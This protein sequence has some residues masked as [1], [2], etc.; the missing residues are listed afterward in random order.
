M[1]TK[2]QIDDFLSLPNIAIFGVSSHAHKFGNDLYKSLRQQGKSVF[3]I[4]HSLQ[5]FEGE[6]C[7]SSLSQLEAN[8]NGVVVCVHKTKAMDIVRE[9]N[10][11]GIRYVWLQKGSESPEVVEYCQNNGIEVIYGYCLLMFLEPVHSVHKFHRFLSRAFRL[12]PT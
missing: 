9:C 4:H 7:F 12:Y 11:R 1:I 6:K 8:P 3:P 5:E 2:T 10:A